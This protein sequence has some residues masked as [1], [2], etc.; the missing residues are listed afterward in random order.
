MTGRPAA[1]LIAA[2]A[3]LLANGAA[4]SV[5]YSAAGGTIRGRVRLDGAIPG[6]P[7][8]RM[9]M[10]PG[11]TA[12]NAGKR[13]VQEAVVASADGGLA[14]VFVKLQGSFPQTPV[15]NQPVLIDQVG[16]I[17][18]PR[19]VGARVG[20]TLRVRNS[21]KLLHN[22]H[23]Q[24][25]KGNTFNVGQPAAGMTND[26]RLTNEEMLHIGCDVHRWM[27]SFV[28]IVNHPYFA[29]SGADG[30]FT[31]AEVPAG[32]YTI[33]AWHEK[34]GTVTQPVRVQPGAAAVV[35]L[36]FTQTK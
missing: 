19:V 32:T 17:Y 31:V 13:R 26:F 16:C 10:D 28:G 34:F 29:V 9:G 22:V 14:N 1:V 4:P 36:T 6:N 3:C 23:S 24:S 18:V 21:D 27:T 30:S 11:C 5:T 20:Q 8:I 7:I 15:P 33:E 12:A 35:T 25:A 2:A